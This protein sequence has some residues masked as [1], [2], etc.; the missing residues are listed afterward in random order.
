MQ[1]AL[2]RLA[3]TAG[4]RSSKGPSSGSKRSKPTPNDSKPASNED[5]G[6]KRQKVQQRPRPT[7][8]FYGVTATDRKW[9]AQITYGGKKRNLGRYD[10]KE[11]A[12]VAYDA[13]AR[14]HAPGRPL[15]YETVEAGKQA[16]AKAEAKHIQQHGANHRTTWAASGFHGVYAND[17]KWQAQIWY[18]GKK[19]HLGCQM[20]GHASPYILFFLELD[21]LFVLGMILP[22]I[23]VML[24][25]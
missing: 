4:T 25:S 23:N 18:D 3:E 5:T 15:N 17:K 20:I 8:G 1:V 11:E 2:L 14:A 19:H 12:A 24:L 13:A 10:T 9:K 6:S 7:S 22:R 21:V 16:A